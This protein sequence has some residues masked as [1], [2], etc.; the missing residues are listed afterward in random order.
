MALVLSSFCS[1]SV[2]WGLGQH[3]QYLTPKQATNAIKWIYITEFFAIMTPNFGRISFA[4]LLLDLIPPQPWR[5][6]LLW[7]LIILQ[8]VVDVAT[9]IV[10]YAQC[11][12]VRGFW[13]HSLRAKCWASYIQ[14]NTG[15]FQGCRCRRTYVL[16]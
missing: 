12:P 4:L 9:V 6:N 7:T 14:A 10:T 15:Y 1:V 3:I 13:D 8:F 2:H 5:R 11:T 16:A